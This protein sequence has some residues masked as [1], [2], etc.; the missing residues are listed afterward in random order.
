[1]DSKF[2]SVLVLLSLFSSVA[3]AQQIYKWKDNT[4]QWH[5]SDHPPAE[6]RAE[7]VRGLDIGPIPPI[8]PQITEP[9]TPS[10]VSESKEQAVSKLPTE[11]PSQVS[12]RDLPDIWLLVLRTGI[13]WKSFDT[14]EACR[15]HRNILSVATDYRKERSGLILS[16]FSGA[17]CVPPDWL[18]PS[19]EANVIM[20][21]TAVQRDPSGMTRLILVGRVFNRG[22]AIASNVVIKYQIRNTMGSTIKKGKIQTDPR[23]LLGMTFADYRAPISVN[24]SRDSVH[25]EV[26]WSKE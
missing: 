23:D 1:M 3:P 17:R 15:R 4:G 26:H 7:K 6:V 5:F 20:V 2:L 13:P 14:A 19:K 12:R 25:T 22:K 11:R 18:Q 8:P 16:P 10:G 24:F 9:S 21:T